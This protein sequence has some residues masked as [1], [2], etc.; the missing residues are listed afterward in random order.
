[1]PVEQRILKI[2]CEKWN[3][4]GGN[5]QS[6]WCSPVSII[7]VCP[8]FYPLVLG[9]VN[10]VRKFSFCCHCDNI[11]LHTL[12]SALWLICRILPISTTFTTRTVSFYCFKFS[13]GNLETSMS[14][15]WM[16]FFWHSFPSYHVGPTTLVAWD[17][18][19]VTTS[20]SH[21]PQPPFSR[22]PLRS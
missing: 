14:H 11:S 4:H 13:P 6:V 20:F 2:A 15:E 9:Q 7:T 22:L 5:Q 21:V 10:G 1:M 12:L 16:A 8:S 18:G 3:Q 17:R 19:W